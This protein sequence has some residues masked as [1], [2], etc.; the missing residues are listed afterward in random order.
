M[1][2]TSQYA[3]VPVAVARKAMTV[4][5]GAEGKALNV[6]EVIT[7]KVEPPPCVYIG[8]NDP[9]GCLDTLTPRIAQNRLLC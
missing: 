5:Y 9:E 4:A 6:T 1:A 7:P 3:S 2:V 8:K